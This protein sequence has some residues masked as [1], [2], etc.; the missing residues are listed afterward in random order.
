MC[1]FVC[2]RALTCLCVIGSLHHSDE[3]SLQQAEV[4]KQLKDTEVRA[5]PA[6]SCVEG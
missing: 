3:D 1:V 5:G 2:L 4:E 6:S